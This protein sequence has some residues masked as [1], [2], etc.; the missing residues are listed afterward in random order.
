MSIKG[1]EG[2]HPAV[3][4]ARVYLDWGAGK[5]LREV[6][7][8]EDIP[9][10]VLLGNDLGW[11]LCHYA[12][13]DTDYKLEGLT[14]SPAQSKVLCETLEDV[15]KC[16]R[17]EGARG[18]DKCLRVAE[19]VMS[20]KGEVGYV[21]TC[22]YNT[23]QMPKPSGEGIGREVGVP[24]V[25]IK[26][27]GPGVSGDLPVSKSCETVMSG[28]KR[29]EEWDFPSATCSLDGEC[30]EQRLCYQEESG[31]QG[32][33]TMVAV[34]TCQQYARAAAVEREEDGNERVKLSGQQA[35]KGVDF[36]PPPNALPEGAVLSG[37]AR[38]GRAIRISWTLC[39]VT[40]PL[41]G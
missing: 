15:V 32:G 40:P 14:E 26:D 19:P 24:Q 1:I 28:S 36:I 27:E 22:D 23:F 5:G 10:N 13:E 3:P 20:S 7:V 21:V 25:T 18:M 39:A 11:M 17:W 16:D 12:P 6:G 35:E 33:I 8:S 30:R 9:V 37:A 4:M 38:W 31:R 2:V 34:V 41:K 29:E